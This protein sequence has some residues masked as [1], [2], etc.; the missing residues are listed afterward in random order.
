[1]PTCAG[2]AVFAGAKASKNG[3]IVQKLVDAGLIILA[4][5]NMTVSN[6]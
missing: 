4:K 3:A 1:M 2:A 6:T 5:G